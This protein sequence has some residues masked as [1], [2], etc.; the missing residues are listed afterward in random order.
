MK[1]KEEDHIKLAYNILGEVITSYPQQISTFS[2][3]TT[4]TSW[5]T[6]KNVGWGQACLS[7]KF[8]FVG[9]ECIDVRN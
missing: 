3:P 6:K 5:K 7:M 2:W 4:P 8:S 1:E 9:W